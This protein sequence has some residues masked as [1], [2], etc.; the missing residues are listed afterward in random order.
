MCNQK[1]FEFGGILSKT[2][3]TLCSKQLN[4]VNFSRIRNAKVAGSAPVFLVGSLLKYN[5]IVLGG[6]MWKWMSIFLLVA[7]STHLIAEVSVLAFSGSTRK[8]SVNKKLVIEAANLA[9]Q[10]GANVTMIDLKDYPIPLYDGDLEAKEGMPQKAKQLQQLMIQNQVIIIASPEY[11]ASVSGVLK[12]AID[13]VSRS[14]NGGSS[15]EAFKGKK[16]VIMSASPSLGG[17]ARG[18]KHLRTIIESVGG[19]VVSDQVVV[20]DA[21]Q[22]FDQQGQLKNPK[23]KLELQHLI[24]TAIQ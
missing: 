8:D 15:Q 12:N 23:L 6:S 1:T 19:T 24:E 10:K 22:A 5:M 20:P 2:A 17:G 7:C 11:N 9:R 16:F 4:C 13:W 14:E 3:L 21:Y 18:L